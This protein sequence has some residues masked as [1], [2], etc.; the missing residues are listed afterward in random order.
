VAD[1]RGGTVGHYR[2]G[3]RGTAW[4]LERIEAGQSPLIVSDGRQTVISSSPGISRANLFAAASDA[5]D[6]VFKIGSGTET[7]LIEIAETLQRA[8]GS[9]R[10]ARIRWPWR[11]GRQ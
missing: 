7:S 11:Q 8:M 10:P 5:T 1:H 6:E 2:G 3:P 4:R 9:T